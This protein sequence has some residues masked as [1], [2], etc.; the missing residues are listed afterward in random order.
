[1]ELN[2]DGMR[3]AAAERGYVV[4]AFVAQQEHH[5]PE[6]MGGY[7]NL[8][9]PPF[10]GENQRVHVAVLA[11]ARARTGSGSPLRNAPDPGTR[12]GPPFAKIWGK[13]PLEDQHERPPQ[14][15]CY[16]SVRWHFGNL[17]P[18]PA[19]D[20]RVY[21]SPYDYPAIRK[22]LPDMWDH[23]AGNARGVPHSLLAD[24]GG[25]H[26]WAWQRWCALDQ[27]ETPQPDAAEA[28]APAARRMG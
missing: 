24:R 9:D 16:I 7:Y 23:A 13:G 10:D 22:T 25:L 8:W 28:P 1:M 3:Y 20:I 17:R 12:F 2:F 6:P 21:D 19:A 27:K 5:G 14:P 15:G 18:Y 4:G 26:A 11:V